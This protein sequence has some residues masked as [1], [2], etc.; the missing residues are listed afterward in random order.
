[1]VD[2]V[3]SVLGDSL[4]YIEELLFQ[5]MEVVIVW[6]AND[7]RL[8]VENILEKLCKVRCGT[9]SFFLGAYHWPK[10]TK[11]I[12][13]RTKAMAIA[14]WAF[15]SAMETFVNPTADATAEMHFTVKAVSSLNFNSIN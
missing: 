15:P 1:M 8:G 2:T 4:K 11:M 12:A 3:H 6:L 9:H 13:T 14:S 7:D 10:S 5:G